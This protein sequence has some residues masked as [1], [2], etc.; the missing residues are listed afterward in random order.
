MAAAL[1]SST[2]GNSIDDNVLAWMLATR[3]SLLTS[4]KC[5]V[6]EASRANACTTRT[7]AYDSANSPVRVATVTRE[8]R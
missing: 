3:L 2:T 6:L 4:S 1:Q 7:P 8:R 5:S